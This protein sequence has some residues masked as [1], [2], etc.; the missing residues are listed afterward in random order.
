M[1]AS[2]PAHSLDQILGRA[3]TPTHAGVNLKRSC[4]R[5]TLPD[6][7]L[8]WG[9]QVAGGTADA[10]AADFA[11]PDDPARRANTVKAIVG[12]RLDI[13]VA[14]AGTTPTALIGARMIKR[15]DAFFMVNIRAPFFLV[16]KSC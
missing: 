2:D 3:G 6:D 8:R 14:S 9:R 16:Q 15:F 12:D 7:L 11:L 10:V 5:L 4:S 1:L 13:L